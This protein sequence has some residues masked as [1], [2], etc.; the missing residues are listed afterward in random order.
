MLPGAGRVLYSIS[1][2]LV[3]IRE[4]IRTGIA[5]Q[6]V[7]GGEVVPGMSLA[8]GMEMGSV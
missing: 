1:T 7:P 2:V 6:M 4:A 8:G 3:A 5:I